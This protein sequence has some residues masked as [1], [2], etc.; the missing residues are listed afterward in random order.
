MFEVKI[1]VIMTAIIA[2]IPAP[3]APDTSLPN[4]IC[5]NSV[6]APLLKALNGLP[7]HSGWKVVPPVPLNS[8]YNATYSEEKIGSK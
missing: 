6:A 3:P 7:V 8:R 5:H 2:V 1:P 4:M